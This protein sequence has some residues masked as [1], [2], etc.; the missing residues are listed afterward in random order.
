M[1]SYKSDP[2]LR[3]AAAKEVS[4]SVQSRKRRE[5]GVNKNPWDTEERDRIM[6]EMA[7]DGA[8]VVEI[9]EAL[10]YSAPSAALRRMHQLGLRAAT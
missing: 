3:Q 2:G 6:R 8:S 10:G 9:A 1:I 7:R 5:V 4:A